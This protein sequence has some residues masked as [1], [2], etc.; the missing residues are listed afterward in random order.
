MCTWPERERER[1]SLSRELSSGLRSYNFPLHRGCF[2]D[3]SANPALD[4]LHLVSLRR[5]IIDDVKTYHQASRITNCTP[6]VKSIL[7][8]H[9]PI[10]RT[11]RIF[12]DRSIYEIFLAGI[13]ICSL[14]SVSSPSISLSLVSVFFFSFR[15]LVQQRSFASPRLK[16]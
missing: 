1:E 5:S 10:S 11:S 2:H 6:R 8:E 9:R 16:V 3:R 12:L 14:F 15:E 4:G 7:L 13:V